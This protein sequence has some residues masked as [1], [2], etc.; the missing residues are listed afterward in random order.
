MRNGSTAAIAISWISGVK[1]A[2][3]SM[4][5]PWYSN[6]AGRVGNGCVGQG[7]SP[8]R[9]VAVSTGRSS[10]GQSGSPVTRS[11]MKTK[12][13]LVICATAFTGRP[14]TTMSTRFGAAGRS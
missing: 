4:V 7:A 12:P 13:C 2:R 3:S 9:S 11:N 14:S 8:S 5:T 1:S 10:I 6:G